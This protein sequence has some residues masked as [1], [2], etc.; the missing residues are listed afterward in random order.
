VELAF[1]DVAHAL[2][3]QDRLETRELA[4][5]LL[6]G[7]QVVRGLRAADVVGWVAWSGRKWF[8]SV[9]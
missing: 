1:L 4:L 6:G 9:P 3:Q 2:A 8:G 7:H 5:D